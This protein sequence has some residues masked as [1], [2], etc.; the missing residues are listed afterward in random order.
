MKKSDHPNP[1]EGLSQLWQKLPDSVAGVSSQP[2]IML[3]GSQS[4]KLT[5]V[6]DNMNTRDMSAL[7]AHSM[8]MGNAFISQCS[9]VPLACEQPLLLE[10]S[11]SSD[12][13]GRSDQLG[14]WGE[15]FSNKLTDFKGRRNFSCTCLTYMPSWPKQ[16]RT[17]FCMNKLRGTFYEFTFDQLHSLISS[18]DL[19]TDTAAILN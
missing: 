5:S 17:R 9:I 15:T 11:P 19:F 16:P 2:G 4:N 8:Q 1:I 10:E 6:Q 12:T 13:Q 18:I 3:P 14:H 7:P